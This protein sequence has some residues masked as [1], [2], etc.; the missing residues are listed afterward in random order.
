MITVGSTCQKSWISLLPMLPMADLMF[1][2]ASIY[3]YHVVIVPA[4][5]VRLLNSSCVTDG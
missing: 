5:V 3:L 1:Q 2:P 4:N